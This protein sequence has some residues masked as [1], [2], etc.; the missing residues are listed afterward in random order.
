MVSNAITLAVKCVPFHPIS[1][2]S[3]ASVVEKGQG[4][5]NAGRALTNLSIFPRSYFHQRPTQRQLKESPKF[6]P[7]ITTNW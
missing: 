3:R 5:R 7:K 2:F 1:V 4:N 6:L